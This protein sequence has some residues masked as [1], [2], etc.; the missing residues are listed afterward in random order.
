MCTYTWLERVGIYLVIKEFPL[1]KEILAFQAVFKKQPFRH[2]FFNFLLEW[3]L[4]SIVF[5]SP[6]RKPSDTSFYFKLPLKLWKQTPTEHPFSL[7]L[8]C[9]LSEKGQEQEQQKRKNKGEDF[10]KS[11]FRPLSS[12]SFF[13]P[14]FFY[15]RFRLLWKDVRNGAGNKR[16]RNLKPAPTSN[17][18]ECI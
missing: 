17:P 5:K 13:F 4:A 11:F 1:E 16:E 10:E 12:F 15:I 8:S 7:Q 2:F 14:F 3:V 6:R 9:S 18:S